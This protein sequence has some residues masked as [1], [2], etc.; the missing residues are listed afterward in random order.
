MRR[1]NTDVCFVNEQGELI[2][3]ASRG[4]TPKYGSVRSV[5]R[6]N[7]AGISRER[8]DLIMGLIEQ[9][10]QSPLNDACIKTRSSDTVESVKDILGKQPPVML[11][12]R[13]VALPGDILAAYYV[14]QDNFPAARGALDHWSTLKPGC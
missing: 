12:Y 10:M 9:V 7:V 2:C 5:L 6:A 3:G 11:L 1:T 14:Q 8:L 13:Y 4:T